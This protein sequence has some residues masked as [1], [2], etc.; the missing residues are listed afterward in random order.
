MKLSVMKAQN[1]L[2]GYIVLSLYYFANMY[3]RLFM[4]QDGDQI[5]IK[6]IFPH[7]IILDLLWQQCSSIA[8]GRTDV[9]ADGTLDKSQDHS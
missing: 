8:R 1:Q 9:E 4:H 6:E 7:C 3:N 5:S 2:Q